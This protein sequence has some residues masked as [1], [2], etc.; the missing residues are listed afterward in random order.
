MTGYSPYQLR[1]PDTGSVLFNGL[2]GLAADIL[3]GF[4][5]AK[6]YR[7]NSATKVVHEYRI[8]TSPFN[9]ETGDTLSVF[10]G[11]TLVTLETISQFNLIMGCATDKCYGVNGATFNQEWTLTLSSVMIS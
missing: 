11:V 2:T 5:S 9:L 8:Y 4:N 10:G 1:H 6:L 7:A 3:V